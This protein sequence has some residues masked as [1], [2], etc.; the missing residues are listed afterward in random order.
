[1]AAQ[2]AQE[3]HSISQKYQH[4]THEEH[5]LN[6]PD[7][8]IGSVEA[9]K[10]EMYVFNEEQEKIVK[11]EIDYIPGLYKIFDEIIVNSLDQYVRCNVMEESEHK[12]RQ[13]K[14]SIDAETGI[15]DVYNDGKGIDIIEHP[16]YKVY[17]PHMIFGKL[18]TSTNYNKKEKKI[19]GGKN[20]YGAKLTNIYSSMFE[21]QTV[22]VERQLHY[23]QVFR[24]NMKNPGTPK[25]KEYKGKPYTRIR[26]LPDYARFGTEALTPDMISLFYKR[27]YDCA[28]L[29]GTDL[30]VFLNKKKLPVK[31]FRKFVELFVGGNDEELDEAAAGAGEATPPPTIIHEKMNE[32][33]EVCLCKSD[34]FDQI[35]YVNS[36]NTFKGGKHVDQVLK[37]LCNEVI[38]F[39][40]KKHKIKLKAHIIR[41]QLRLFLRCNVMNPSFD[42]QTKEY[43]TTPYSRMG[44]SFEM[45]KKLVKA[46]LNLGILEQA[47]AIAQAKEMK[48]LTKNE[49]KKKNKIRGIPKL[50]DATYAGTAKSQQCTL[51]LTEGDSAATTAISGL[52]VIGKDY[53]GVF[54][55]K[56]KLI[57]VREHNPQ[58]VH[59]NEE[60]Q[61]IKKIIGLQTGM[62]YEDVSSLR[63]GSVIVL[64]DQDH[65]G[66]HIKG[67][68]MNMFHHE[69]PELLERRYVKSMLTPIIKVFK[70]KKEQAFYTIQDYERW[71][72][73]T[74]DA[75]RWR[76]K[77]YKGLGT[78]SP[79]EA[80]QYF[81]DMN[82]LE[83]LYEKRRDNDKVL[84]AFAKEKVQSRK[85]W[86]RAYNKEE[87][88]NAKERQIQVDSFIDKELI[89]FSNADNIRSLPNVIDGLKKSQRKVLFSCFK[90]NLTKEIRVAQLAGYVS[91]HAGYHHG[92]ASLNGTIINMAQNFLDSNNINLL[93]PI[94]QFGSRLLGG[95]DAASPRY[96]HTCLEKIASVIFRSADIPVLDHLDDDGLPVEPTYYAPII[97]MILVNGSS[98]IGTGFSTDIPKY[99]VR[100]VIANLE[101]RIRGEELVD[102]APNYCGFKGTIDKVN[103]TTFVARGGY[104]VTL[105]KNTVEILELPPGT[106]TRNYKEMLEKLIPDTA[107]GR[108][109]KKCVKSIED[110][111]NDVD[112]YFKITFYPGYLDKLTT[113]TTKLS[114]G[115]EYEVNNLEKYLKLYQVINLTNIHGFDSQERLR[116][117]SGWQEIFDEFYSTRLGVYDKRK[118]DQLRVMDGRLEVLSEK[119]RFIRAVVN[120]ELN[121]MNAEDDELVERMGQDGMNF[122]PL[123][124]AKENDPLAVWHYLLSMHVRTLTKK[125]MEELQREHDALVEE[126]N[127]LRATS[128]EDIWLQELRELKVEYAQFLKHKNEY[129]ENM[130]VENEAVAGAGG[131][132]KVKRRRRVVKKK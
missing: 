76:T 125:K 120:K 108:N 102:M 106:W 55:L 64:T 16:K 68:V 83:Y 74:P 39:A 49:G 11:R 117:F 116:K 82:L 53:F 21:I 32:H 30:S 127:T 2:P 101:R 80:R 93:K 44:T 34:A 122:K 31:S 25:I 99:D 69:W 6:V 86:L 37:E 109:M 118:K 130:K 58:K 95:K 57:N 4:H 52:K 45:P 121:I 3:N 92:E 65:D 8:Y 66:S 47:M 72:E 81:R 7:T 33:W 105:S 73:A 79:A 94:G 124:T 22:D 35:S 112:V 119:V 43:L 40:E 36:V 100:E 13:L 42:S 132:K 27:V 19:V 59:S 51:I 103:D 96:I 75:S 1:M 29:T 87:T 77:Y 28:G 20:G 48:A 61:N 46:V 104:K 123:D 78:S 38:A 10:Q 50:E 56:G 71:A 63:Y 107:G 14:V 17:V 90:R 128:L 89:H 88:I 97:P 62:K 110:N 26:F 85:A 5:I 24:N 98:G 54:P 23:K 60:I 113:R 114:K 9:V 126:R 67:L 84:L 131:G 15:I 115:S 129:L 111:Y 18:L 41:D 91:E 12:V 70:G